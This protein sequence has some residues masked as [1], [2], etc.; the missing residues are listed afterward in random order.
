M[1]RYVQLKIIIYKVFNFYFL[2]ARIKLVLEFISA[3]LMEEIE[4]RLKK[5][6]HNGP[7]KRYILGLLNVYCKL[8]AVCSYE[9]NEDG[10]FHCIFWPT[11]FL[12]PTPLDLSPEISI[13]NG[14]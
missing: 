7:Y 5:R 4:N 10:H 9:L 3:D 14:E 12:L 8:S 1:H 13:E 2:E 11:C 6:R